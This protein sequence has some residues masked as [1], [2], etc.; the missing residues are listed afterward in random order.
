M[1]LRQRSPLYIM[2]ENGWRLFLGPL[3]PMD[4]SSQWWRHGMA[5]LRRNGVNDKLVNRFDEI[6]GDTVE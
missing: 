3:T 4:V 1:S 6:T 5:N 2:T